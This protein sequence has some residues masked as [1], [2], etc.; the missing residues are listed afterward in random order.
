M[1]IRSKLGLYRESIEKTPQPAK[2][3]GEP[4]INVL[5]PGRVCKN[6]YG[7][8][9]VIENRYAPDHIHGGCE[10]GTALNIGSDVLAAVGGQDCSGLEARKLIYLDTETTGLSGGTGTVAFL[11]GVGFFEDDCYV[12]RQYFIRDY[13]EE[14][15]ML[16]ELSGLF[17]RA[18]GLVTFNGKA[19]DINLLQSRFISNRMRAPFSDIPNIDLLYPARRVWGQK[20]ESCRLSSLE[21]NVL[22]QVRHDDIQGALIPSVYFEYLEDRDA[23]EIVRVIKHNGLDILSMVSLL[24][25]L[26]A[27]L[28]DPL[29]KTD[30]GLELLGMGRIFEA[31]GKTDIMVEC[32]EACTD[33]QRFDIRIQAVKRLTRIYKRA[34]RY[35]RAMEHWKAV[36]SE[37]PEFELFHL[38]EMA[39]YF[40]HKEKDPEK[41]LQ[42]VEKALQICLRP[43]LSADRSLEELKKRRDRLMRK[44]HNFS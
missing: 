24:V 32:L 20:L 4:D 25:R 18:A 16:A 15:A 9:Y 7:C 36:E 34:G 29:S 2:K 12:L 38:I 17:S 27:M 22:G 30:G 37:N 19:F 10:I 8:C 28:Q 11:V 39:K 43:G 26:Q 14:P 23:S 44:S 3:T 41:A 42:I 5:V 40:E 21:E 13:D 33:S 31:T 35:D 1:D 6:E